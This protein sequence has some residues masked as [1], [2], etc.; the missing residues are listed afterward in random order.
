[1]SF[2]WILAKMDKSMMAMTAAID[3][4][5]R[6]LPPSSNSAT[7]TG[8][9]RRPQSKM[10]CQDGEESDRNERK[11]KKAEF[12]L[13]GQDRNAPLVRSIARSQPPAKIR[14]GLGIFHTLELNT[15]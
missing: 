1:M 7:Q 12:A 8:R 5:G 3:S 2:P 13:S 11:Q 6:I 10:Q 4:A 14:P 15:R 9:Q